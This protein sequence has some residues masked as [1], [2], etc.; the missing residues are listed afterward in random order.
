MRFVPRFYGD[1]E[2]GKLILHERNSFHSYLASLSGKVELLLYPWKA[3]RT[4]KQNSYFHA[5]VRLICEETGEA[6]IERMKE[7]LKDECGEKVEITRFGKTKMVNKSTADYSRKEM[8]DFITRI[9]VL[10]G[11]PAPDSKS[12][13]I[14]E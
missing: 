4:L 14:V 7:F 1:V 5:Y 3:K 12:V 6:E 13:S 11:V 8:I 10:S 9:E 2:N